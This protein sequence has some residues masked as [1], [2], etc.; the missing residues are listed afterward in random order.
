MAR[1]DFDRLRTMAMMRKKIAD[2][3]LATE[4]SYRMSLHTCIELFYKPLTAAAILQE[5][6]I[7]RDFKRRKQQSVNSKEVRLHVV[8]SNSEGH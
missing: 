6:K 5:Q 2:E 8:H 4:R 7:T 1:K 3:L